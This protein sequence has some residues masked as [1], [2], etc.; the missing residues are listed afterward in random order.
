[1]NS[2][3]T[4]LNVAPTRA[5]SERFD[6]TIG[7]ATVL[8]PFGGKTQLTPR[9]PW[10][11]QDLPVDGETTTCSGMAW[12]FNPYLMSADQFAGAYLAVV[13]SGRQARCRRREHKRMYLSFQEYFE[14]CVTSPSAGASPWQPLLGALDGAGRP[15]VPAPSAARTP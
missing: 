4:D 2:L 1:M 15:G 7:A 11:R 13:E 10:R 14:S 12:G 3:V 9:R 6:S 8:M 5:L